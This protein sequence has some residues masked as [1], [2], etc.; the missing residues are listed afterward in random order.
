[1]SSLAVTGKYGSVTT[2]ASVPESVTGV[3]DLTASVSGYGP[4]SLAG[5]TGTVNLIDSSNA[6]VQLAPIPLSGGM[7]TRALA[8]GE[9]TALPVAGVG[10]VTK[11][12]DFNGDG[13]PDVA[14]DN[15][16]NNTVQIFLGAGDGSFQAGASFSLGGTLAA[17]ADLN[18]DGKLDLIMIGA[19]NV[20]VLLGN[21]DGTFQAQTATFATGDGPKGLAAGDFTGDGNL[22]LIVAVTN[23][24]A[25]LQ[26]NGDGTF[27]PAQTTALTGLDRGLSTVPLTPEAVSVGDFNGDGKLDVA[28]ANY[29]TA[30]STSQGD[31]VS[32]LLGN[33][34]GTFQT[35]LEY[36]T[37]QASGSVAIGDFNGDGKPDLTVTSIATS[38]GSESQSTVYVLIG[39]G[40]GTFQQPVAYALPADAFPNSVQIADFDGD[41]KA[42]LMVS[43]F[44]GG[45]PPDAAGHEDL[46][47]V[48]L[49]NGDGTFQPQRGYFPATTQFGASNNLTVADFNGDGRP[50]VIPLE[51]ATTGSV[52]ATVL[53]NLG[54]TTTVTV[55]AVAI[56]GGETQVIQ[57]TY[58]G[59][60]IYSTSTSGAITLDGIAPASLT[61]ATPAAITYGTPLSTTQLN[62]SSVVAGTFVYTP[63][64]G[65]VLGAGSQTLSVT[66][67]P[68]NTT[69]Y[70]PATQTVKLSVTQ[71]PLNA[72]V[73]N[74]A[75]VYGAA[76]P[77]FAGALTGAVNGDVLTE[78]FTTT[79]S[80][81]SIVGAY[82]IVPA[83]SGAAAANYAVSASN[84]T[85][86]ISQ[87][88]STT[89]FALSN[90]NQVLTAT[91]TSVTAGTPS[92]KVSFFGGQTLIGTST[93]A[94]GVA[95]YTLSTTP[96]ASTSITAQYQGDADFTESYSPATSILS[97]ASASTALTLTSGTSVTDTLTLAPAPGYQ[98]TVQFAC[99]GL[100]QNA[101][102]G[103]SP[104]TIAFSGTNSPSDVVLT[105]KSGTGTSAGL[106]EFEPL[107][108]GNHPFLPAAIFGVPGCLAAVAGMKR[109]GK[110][111]RGG[112][113]F[114]VFALGGF[115]CMTACSSGSA[116]PPTTTSTTTPAGTS[117]VQITVT[118]TGNLT[119]TVNLSLTVK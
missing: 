96:S 71:A 30:Q 90:Q 113:L 95:T 17:V 55:P 115:A 89:S 63:A 91:V 69:D 40:N 86:T 15:G 52:G 105:I 70:A 49:G 56:P 64:V 27:Q 12:G 23:G 65:T 59:D 14:V 117:S 20:S 7:V 44:L 54:A 94:G 6:A 18:N 111:P 79:A 26:G 37:Q 53:L 102:C 106:R 33:G 93:L 62:A 24:L 16:S 82:P 50:D 103:F 119:Q 92:G 5:P 77:T 74:A 81:T 67:T 107:S 45:D 42:D 22:D 10:S 31:S 19:G 80:G 32:V 112:L 109:K 61:W 34:D 43:S 68:A 46:F 114:L 58:S 75:R 29:G 78:T 84:G 4:L 51:V 72:T 36:T 108:P 88:G 25:L 38:N 28:S 101:T 41:G 60:T 83:V 110:F 48:L 11:S 99:S 98:G 1:M 8:F 21:G 97:L 118:G 85:L 66:F 100:P 73:T 3:Y 87:A 116:T 57:A 39:N 35:P 2:L 76:N 13:K 9:S 104:S 47:L